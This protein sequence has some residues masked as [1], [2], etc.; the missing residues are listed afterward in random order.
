MQSKKNQE[1]NII[2]TE[3]KNNFPKQCW[4][5][6]RKILGSLETMILYIKLFSIGHKIKHFFLKTT[7]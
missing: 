1:T 5:K 6:N 7:S 3:Y 4:I 2:Y